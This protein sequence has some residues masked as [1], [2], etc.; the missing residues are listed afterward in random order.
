MEDLELATLSR[1]WWFNNERLFGPIGHMPPIELLPPETPLHHGVLV[2][3]STELHAQL[4][5]TS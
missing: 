5:Q 1:V 3:M 2:L 4:L